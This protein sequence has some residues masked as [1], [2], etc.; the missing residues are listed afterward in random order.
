MSAGDTLQLPDYTVT[1]GSATTTRY[2]NTNDPSLFYDYNH[3]YSS[4][5]WTGKVPLESARE[6][7]PVLYT[8]GTFK[9]LATLPPA[10]TVVNN[11]STHVPSRYFGK[12]YTP[13]KKPR[14]VLIA[15][16]FNYNPTGLRTFLDANDI[17]LF[18]NLLPARPLELG[19]PVSSVTN[20]NLVFD[21]GTTPCPVTD[22]TKYVGGDALLYMWGTGIG[23]DNGGVNYL[24]DVAPL[25]P[26]AGSYIT[27][28]ESDYLTDPF[29]LADPGSVIT[30]NNAVFNSNVTQLQALAERFDSFK[31][32]FCFGHA[33]PADF[34]FAGDPAAFN[35]AYLSLLNGVSLNT[36]TF[37][38]REFSSTND[39][40]LSDADVLADCASFFGL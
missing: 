9:E 34:A 21:A 36:G 8:T 14:A 29:D 20:V 38:V 17:H 33:Q 2:F 22:N 30:V 25:D 5:D 10:F 31:V 18:A 3:G 6:S 27:A 24:G 37:T 35:A 16:S 11:A 40:S 4:Q 23:D 28:Y 7:Y 1:S 12:Q 39:P 15:S 32:I 19:L 26:E 13:I